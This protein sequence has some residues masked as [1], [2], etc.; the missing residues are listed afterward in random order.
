MLVKTPSA[1]TMLKNLYVIQGVQTVVLK[2]FLT[3]SALHVAFTKDVKFL[4]LSLKKELF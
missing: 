2:N 1:H 4:H 3:L